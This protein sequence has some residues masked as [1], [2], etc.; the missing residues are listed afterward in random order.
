MSPLLF[1]LYID[2]LSLAIKALGKGIE[3]KGE[4][5]SI[6]LYADDIILLVNTAEELQSMINCGWGI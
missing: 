5:V 2:D 6:L 1:S 4:Q 3:I